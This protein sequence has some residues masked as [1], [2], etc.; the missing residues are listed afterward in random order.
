MEFLTKL[1]FRS[2]DLA[3]RVY[4]ALKVAYLK[5]QFGAFGDGSSLTNSVDAV[6]PAHVFIGR[7]VTIGRNVLLW[8]SSKGK[9]VIGDDC[10]ISAGVRF[11]TP[12][13][14]YRILPVSRVGIN[15]SIVVGKDVWIGAV[16]T[17]LPGITIHDGAVVAAG[18]VVS[19]DVP[20]DCIVGGVPARIIKQLDPR[21][22]RLD[23][24]K[25]Q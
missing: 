10:A 12:T 8:A 6:W 5:S 4:G 17:I 21:N 3:R 25:E 18:A 16:A 1:M 23:R 15:K 7:N 13:H 20:H 2:L 24:G 19:K 9:I 11:I 22:I 14:D